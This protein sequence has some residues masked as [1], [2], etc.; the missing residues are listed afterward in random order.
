MSDYTKDEL[1]NLIVNSPEEYNEWKKNQ[2]DEVDLSEMDFSS[3]NL[4]QVDLS[5]A[6]LNG[7]AFADAHLVEVNFKNADY[8]KCSEL[9]KDKISCN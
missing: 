9:S 4:E 8:T 1:Y 2:T 3:V 6:D 5:D 7:S